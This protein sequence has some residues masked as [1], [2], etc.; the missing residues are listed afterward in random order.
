MFLGDFNIDLLSS[1][2]SAQDITTNMSAFHFHQVVTDP[3]RISPSSSTLIGHVYVSDL[4][5][6]S[7]C[8]TT[9]PLGSS[10]HSCVV[11][12]LTQTTTRPS[13]LCHLMWSY[14]TANWD[15]ANDQLSE[16]LPSAFPES[17]DIDSIWASWKSQFLYVMSR[18]IPSRTITV[19]K[20]LP[21]L[22]ADIMHLL[23]KRD[24]FHRLAKST[25]SSKIHRK[26]CYFRNK[27][28]SMVHKAK[29]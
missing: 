3:T 7:S 26:F 25:G 24:Y 5:F 28:V 16:V 11:V 23:K 27:A 1:S 29:H 14:R 21:W 15:L 18:C 9:P 13:K 10:D 19:K 6:L 20:S 17:S 4:S 8:S 2:P 12:A 22:D